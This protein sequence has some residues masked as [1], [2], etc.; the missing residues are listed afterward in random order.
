[1]TTFKIQP[2]YGQLVFTRGSLTSDY[3]VSLYDYEHCEPIA[4]FPSE[5]FEGDNRAYAE[6]EALMEK[7]DMEFVDY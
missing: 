6:M 3:G 4:D 5:S 7:W 2:Y 1:M